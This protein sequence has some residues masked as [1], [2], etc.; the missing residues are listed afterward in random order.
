MSSH[1][2]NEHEFSKL[3]GY[4]ALRPWIITLVSA[5]FFMYQF[6]Q[7]NMFNALGP[8]MLDSFH[9]DAL[10]L[11]NLSAMSIYANV[12]LLP[13]AGIILDRFSARRII[14]IGMLISVLFTGLFSYAETYWL[15]AT[16]R[17]VA[18][19]AGAFCFLGCIV[20]ASR[21]F[22]ASKMAIAS[23]LIV[24][25]GM[26]GGA[27]AQ[28][29]MAILIEQYGWHVAVRSYAFL[30]VIFWLIMFV[31]LADSADKKIVHPS[32]KTTLAGLKE[33]ACVAFRNTQNWLCGGYT[34]AMNLI[35][36]V[37]GA[38]WGAGYLESVHNIGHIHATR[39]TSFIFYGT[40]IGSPLVGAFSDSLKKRRMPM[41]VG[42]WL[43]LFLIMIVILSNALNFYVLSF[44]FFML[45]VTT[46]AQVLTY[47]VIAESNAPEHT[48]V[49]EALASFMIM[50]SG[51]ICQDIFGMLMNYHAIGKLHASQLIHYNASD[52]QFAFWLLPVG[53]VLSLFFGYYVKETNAKSM[54]S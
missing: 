41:L 26:L 38:I 11:G 44:L 46:S 7:V 51:A 28:E 52:Y 18:G 6:A 23:G 15:A 20:M 1:V 35:I 27:L 21:W 33:S 50:G 31:T 5:F 45:G 17:F 12:L 22:P 32:G 36:L 3:T 39:I 54:L 19:T 8:A 43:S 24:T 37:I 47:P 13:V 14:L 29:P 40:M 2:V 4:S 16:S 9:I 25:M 10:Q 34:S 48:G 30:G 42:A 53:F 49:C